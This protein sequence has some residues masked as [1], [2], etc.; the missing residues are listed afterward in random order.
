MHGPCRALPLLLAT[1]WHLQCC[2]AT[3]FPRPNNKTHTSEEVVRFLDV[4]NRSSCQPKEAMVS[5]TSEHPYMVNHIVMPSCVALKRCAGCCADES[6]QC[7]P[8]RTRELVMEVMLTLF[9]HHRLNQLTFLEH[10]QCACRSKKTPYRFNA[11][12]PPCRPCL[13]R[14]KRLDPPSCRCVCRSDS[15]HC[16]ARGLTF[17]RTTCRCMNLHHR[18]TNRRTKAAL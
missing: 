7:V 12:R 4:Y 6:L 11:I 1:A 8:T 9:P 5:V 14:K 18:L 3:M 10:T 16:E 13:D 15:K 2:A 17:N